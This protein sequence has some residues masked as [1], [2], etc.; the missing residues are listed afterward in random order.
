M[1][2]PHRFE[3]DHEIG[4]EST[5]EGDQDVHG[6]QHVQGNQQVDGKL[7]AGEVDSA[8]MYPDNIVVTRDNIDSYGTITEELVE[9]GGGN[10]HTVYDG[11]PIDILWG[12]I[13]GPLVR[14]VWVTFSGEDERE[15]L[16]GGGTNQRSRAETID[17]DGHEHEF[18]VVTLP[19]VHDVE[20]IEFYSDST[21]NY[22][23]RIARRF[24]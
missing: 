20:K 16:Y 2:E 4:G 3:G 19:P 6:D 8:E 1:T 12:Y 24:L 14:E 23:W 9:V 15:T 17:S 18:T 5:V 10:E 7:S 21:G 11:D 13:K 22:G